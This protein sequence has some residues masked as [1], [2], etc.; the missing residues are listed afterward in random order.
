MLYSL[1]WLNRVAAKPGK[2]EQQS[3]S[4]HE[5]AQLQAAEQTAWDGV[6]RR[7]AAEAIHKA[8]EALGSP[9]TQMEA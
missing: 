3:Q 2:T 8:S 5:P 4:G 6:R 7:L 1:G 9:K